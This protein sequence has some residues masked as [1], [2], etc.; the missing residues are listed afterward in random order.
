[1]LL[2]CFATGEGEE[3]K[4]CLRLL[5]SVTDSVGAVQTAPDVDREVKPEKFPWLSGTPTVSRLLLTH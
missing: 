1:M 3:M 2:R 5:R 4:F